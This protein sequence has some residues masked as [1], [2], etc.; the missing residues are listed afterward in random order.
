MNVVLRD[1]NRERTYLAQVTQDHDSESLFWFGL[2]FYN[3]SQQRQAR[4]FGNVD[5]RAGAQESCEFL[6]YALR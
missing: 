3:I 4:E 6:L 1:S 2:V 5:Q